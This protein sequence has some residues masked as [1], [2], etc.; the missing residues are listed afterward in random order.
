VERVLSVPLASEVQPALQELSPALRKLAACDYV[1]GVDPVFIGL[2]RFAD[3]EDG[4]S[5]AETAHCCWPEHAAHS[6]ERTTGVLPSVA[7]EWGAAGSVGRAQLTLEHEHFHVI[8]H[9]VFGA[10]GRWAA[11]H[12]ELPTV[13]EY[14][15][16]DKWERF[17]CAG[18]RYLY[19][20]RTEWGQVLDRATRRWF[21]G[22]ASRG[23]AIFEAPA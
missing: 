12:V 23:L 4:R 20:E 21:D 6:R 10:T 2:H 5:Y 17:A 1:L 3:C 16:R 18:Q 19:P 15:A 22:F 14:A 11:D 9:A 13:S 7:A 8:D